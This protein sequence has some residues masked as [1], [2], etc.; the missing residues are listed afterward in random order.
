[1]DITKLMKQASQLQA[2]LKQVTQEVN[3][4]EFTE[5]HNDLISC[6]IKGDLSITNININ[7]SLLEP[8]NKEILE[9][10]LKLVIN[11]ALTKATNYKEEKMKGLTGGLNIPGL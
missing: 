6:T 11:N 3:S 5:T 9:D 4:L 10:Y 8:S 2:N 1:M 7:E